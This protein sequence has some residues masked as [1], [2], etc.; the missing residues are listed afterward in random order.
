MSGRKIIDGLEEA[1]LS[2]AEPVWRPED[3][4]DFI[5]HGYR[6]L[7]AKNGGF[8]I[9]GS[10]A[11]RDTGMLSPIAA[12]SNT[13]ELL[14]FLTWLHGTPAREPQRSTD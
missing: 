3:F 8:V 10:M 7:P 11:F 1:L 14:R 4:R 5:A 2:L 12:V 9:D 6:V 13:S